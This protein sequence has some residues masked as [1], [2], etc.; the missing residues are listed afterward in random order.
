MR[1]LDPSLQIGSPQKLCCGWKIVQA[2][3][4]DEHPAL[5]AGHTGMSHLHRL[6]CVSGGQHRAALRPCP[7]RLPAHRSASLKVIAFEG[8]KPLSGEAKGG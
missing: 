2:W 6:E 3:A 5:T 8:D 1:I 7:D 4:S